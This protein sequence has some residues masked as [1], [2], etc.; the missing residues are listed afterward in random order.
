MIIIMLTRTTIWILNMS[1]NTKDINKIQS[2]DMK[3]LRDVE[4]CSILDKI[5]NQWLIDPKGATPV[6]WTPA[7]DWLMTARWYNGISITRSQVNVHIINQIHYFS[8]KWLP[9]CPHETEWT[10]F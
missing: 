9:N 1:T 8:I 3:F 2:A 6:N 7:T 5:L 10:P 4:S